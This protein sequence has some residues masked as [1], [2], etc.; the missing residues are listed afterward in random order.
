M[1]PTRRTVLA[2]TAGLL[3]APALGRTGPR[4]QNPLPSW[5]AGPVRNALVDFVARTTSFSSSD[6]VPPADR[7]AVFDNDGTLWCE[8]PV[9]TQ[10]AFIADRVKVLAPMHPEWREKEPFKS[11]LA[12]DMK[13]VA[14]SGEHG[15]VEL[16][17]A[18][19]AGMTV[20]EFHAIVIDWLKTARH[21][22]FGKPYTECVYAPMV[23]LLGYLREKG[24]TTYI[25]SGGGVEFMRP[26]AERVYGIPPGQVIGS[27]IL[28]EYKER[29]GTPVLVRLPKIDFVDDKA[30]KPVGIN[31]GI[32]K[33]PVMAFGN[34]DG[35][36][37]ML[38]YTTAGAGPRFGLIVHHTDAGREYAYDKDSAVGRLDKALAEAK[39]RGWAV[40]DMKRDWKRVF[41]FE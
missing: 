8:K 13:G 11:L 1:N 3:V 39:E 27:S 37:E 31:R 40:A 29:D 10:A 33:R 20:D 30:G 18:T 4:D 34:S 26:W 16:V 36:Y 32:G 35:D 41:A 12:G 25:V 22:K 14:G 23:E 9:Y 15:L 24:Y 6:F 5:N 28:T 19:H 17:A 38:R 21:P 7:V 2:S